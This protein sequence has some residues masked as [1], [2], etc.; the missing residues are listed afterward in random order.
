M[1]NLLRYAA[2]FLMFFYRL[3]LLAWAAAQKS[4]FAS[5]GRNVTINRKCTFSYSN[6]HLGDNVFIGEGALFLSALSQIY[7][8]SNVM[9][10]P[11]VTIIGGDHRV[12]V[13][14]EYMINVGIR[15]KLPEHDR[16]VVIEDDVWVGCNVTILSGV[17]VGEGSVIG[18]GSV[19]TRDVPPYTVLVGSPPRQSWPRWDAETIAEHKRLLREKYDA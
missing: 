14:G 2:R 12:D 3:P 9:F 10:G 16:D 15:D 4:L 7:I 5:C 18:A 19:V 6:V 13:V 17:T 1:P 11:H 8:G